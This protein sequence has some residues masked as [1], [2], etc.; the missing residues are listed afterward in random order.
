M[1]QII[2][3]CWVVRKGTNKRMFVKDILK[4]THALCT[5]NV[6]KTKKYEVILLT[7]LETVE[8]YVG[9]ITLRPKP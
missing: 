7:E 5:F 9:I 8:S 1:T 4:Q 3:N 2:K 6:K